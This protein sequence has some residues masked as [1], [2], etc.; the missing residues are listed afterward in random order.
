MVC[1]TVSQRPTVLHTVI[2]CD[3][4]LFTNLV[5]EIS[6]GEARGGVNWGG[7]NAKPQHERCVPVVCH[8]VTSR[9]QFHVGALPNS[10][11]EWGIS[12]L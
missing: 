5:L 9:Q 2:F 3:K 1:K 4:D 11:R 8:L 7:P 12:F 6:E 10:V